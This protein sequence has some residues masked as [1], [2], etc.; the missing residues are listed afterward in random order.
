MLYYSW[1][2]PIVWIGRNNN[3]TLYIGLQSGHRRRRRRLRIH[4]RVLR[5]LQAHY[6]IAINVNIR[7]RSVIIS[8]RRDGR[9]GQRSVVMCVRDAVWQTSIVSFS[10]KNVLHR[11]TVLRLLSSSSARGYRVT[12]IRRKKI[13]RPS[14]TST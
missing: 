12:R 8:C 11:E 14:D 6:E 3:I 13:K 9:R 7:I 5:L 4:R 2:L 1:Y 10:G